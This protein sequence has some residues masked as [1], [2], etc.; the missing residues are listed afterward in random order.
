MYPNRS[1]G[2]AINKTQSP[3][4]YLQFMLDSEVRYGDNEKFLPGLSICREESVQFSSFQTTYNYLISS[5][6]MVNKSPY[7]PGCS[8]DFSL[9]LSNSISFCC[10]IKYKV[11]ASTFSSNFACIAP[12]STPFS[13]TSSA[14]GMPGK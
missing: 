1:D 6:V 9:A 8:N 4:T 7:L 12:T 10:W 13:D 3:E 11:N 14:D 5:I 2:D